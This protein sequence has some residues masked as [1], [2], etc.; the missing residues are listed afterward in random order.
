MYKA[1]EVVQVT[2]P[3]RKGKRPVLYSVI[4]FLPDTITDEFINVGI[5]VHDL[6]TG[7]I[8]SKTITNIDEIIRRHPD[9][10]NK[11]LTKLVIKG[12]EINKKE[13]SRNFLSELSREEHGI[14]ERIF[15]RE[16]LPSIADITLDEQIESIWKTFITIEPYK[17][18][19]AL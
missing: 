6:E 5:V 8:K 11:I 15:Y 1:D 9:S 2:I 3:I 4:K 17:K 19:G 14:Y 10:T 12:A 7:E 16:P 18:D 13:S